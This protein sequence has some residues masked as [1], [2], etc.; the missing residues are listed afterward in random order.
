MTT[1]RDVREN[2]CVALVFNEYVRTYSSLN[3]EQ[4]EEKEEEDDDD[5]EKEDDDAGEEEM[6]RGKMKL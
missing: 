6:K 4:E 1:R 2:Q 5:E 3:N